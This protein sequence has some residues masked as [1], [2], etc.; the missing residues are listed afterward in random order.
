LQ[1]E[2]RDFPQTRYDD[3]MDSVSLAC[4]PA[5]IERAPKAE[6]FVPTMVGNK[7]R[8][9]VQKRRTRYCGI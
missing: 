6:K 7:R 5:V 3:L 1:Q 2:N 9:G 8:K 4:D